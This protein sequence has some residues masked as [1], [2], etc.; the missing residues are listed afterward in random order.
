MDGK[1]IDQIISGMEAREFIKD[2][3]EPDLRQWETP[4]NRYQNFDGGIKL[5]PYSDS[6]AMMSARIALLNPEYFNTES[7]K[8]YFYNIL[9]NQ[10]SDIHRVVAA[11][12]GL[13]AFNEP[14]LIDIYELLKDD[15]L[16]Q[17][18]R[19]MLALGL[20]ALGEKGSASDIYMKILS[21]SVK[22]DDKIS[23]DL[24][25]DEG[26]NFISTGLL[27]T[28]AVKL[29]DYKNGDKMF[30]YLYENPSKYEI[31]YIERLIYII[32]RNIMHSE[33]IKALSGKVTIKY[34]G[35]EEIFD[36]FGFESKSIT[37][38]PKEMESLKIKTATGDIGAYVYALGGVKDMRENKTAEFAITKE[39]KTNDHKT[40]EFMQSDLI[41]VT[42]S[43]R[44]GLN[45]KGTYRIT[46][47][48]PAGFRFVKIEKNN[49]WYEEEGQKIIFYYWN[50]KNSKGISYYIQAVMPR[51][52]TADHT[53][54]TKNGKV[55]TNFTEQEVLIVK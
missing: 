49:S 54:I 1:R 7:M 39:Y 46:D 37:L 19:I 38:T 33:Q 11:Y 9:Y 51:K 25:T 10:N 17:T 31:A 20:E 45:D 15:A 3:F 41:K 5:L 50:S 55:G 48:I 47:F 23:F 4:V 18:D 53:V 35:N 43:P 28:L 2:N 24:S 29:G 42:L 52:Y 21:T 12:T 22:L 6:D 34:L 27:S 14:V 13:A 40:N 36:I 44:V 8:T 32:N 30:D 26:E 16:T